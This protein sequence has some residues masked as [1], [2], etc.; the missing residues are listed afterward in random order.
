MGVWKFFSLLVI[1]QQRAVLIRSLIVKNICCWFFFRV[2]GWLYELSGDMCRALY[3]F[4]CF[5]SSRFVADLCYR[6][7][8]VIVWQDTDFYTEVK[9]DFIS[10]LNECLSKGR[11]LRPVLVKK[12]VTG[13]HF[14]EKKVFGR[15][16]DIKS[17][18]GTKI[19]LQKVFSRSDSSIYNADGNHMSLQRGSLSLIRIYLSL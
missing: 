7:L 9:C 6:L 8:F 4:C 11:V 1:F 5:V 17:T 13:P 18:F 12:V 14:Y 16:L 19:R 3:Y 2:F 15:N 10:S